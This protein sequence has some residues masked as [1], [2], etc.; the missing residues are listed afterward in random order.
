MRGSGPIPALMSRFRKDPDPRFWRLNRSIEFDWR[1]APYDIDQ[2][3]AHARGL[4]GIGVLDAEELAKIDAG[5]ERVR[6]RMGEHGFEFD[7][8][9]E[10][11]HMAVERLLGEE[12]GPLA[13]KLHTGRSRN[14]QVAT[15]VAMVVQAHSLRAIELAGDAMER[16]LR[17]AERHRDWPMP[18]Y[19]HLQRAQPVYLGH[20]LLAYFWMLARDVL[21]F[22][23][24]LDGASVMPLGSG[25]LAGVNWE[26]DRNAVADDLGFEHVSHN[27][28]DGASNRDFVLD[29]LAAASTCAMHLSRLG[30]EIVIWSS[31]EFGFCELDES[32]SSGSSIMPQKVNPD[33]AE[34]LR[35]KSPRVAASYASLLGTMH[36]LPLTYGKD[37]QEDKE[38]LFDA[39]DTIESCLE[40][41]E[42]MLAGIEFDR[43]RLE[44]ASGDEMLAATEVA[45]LLV[46]RGVPFRE[47]H[48]I[49][50]GLVRDAVEQD[51]KL[52][53]LSPEEIAARSEHLDESFYEVLQ[54]SSWLESK[55]IEGGTGSEALGVQIG[56]AN[57]T[58]A[59]VRGRVEDERS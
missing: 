55:R 22:Q 48:G 58:L 31:S 14:D 1:L 36:A 19:T 44:A 18:G 53:E 25:A 20:H 32:F 47:A 9:D 29:Y 7:D 52:S 54:R 46:R 42:G 57:E 51:K 49:V 45:D 50:G 28:I 37:M 56:Q 21:R 27:S 13:G 16:L 40:A 39:I 34:L 38:P 10:D 26:I 6:A 17:L 33:S 30:S 35:A 4:H 23:F 2:S 15:D 24:A 43:E 12:I 41:L 59:A 3:Q 11:I 5:L 8:A